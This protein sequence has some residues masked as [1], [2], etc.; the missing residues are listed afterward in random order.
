MLLISQWPDVKNGEY[1]LIEKIKQTGYKIVVTDYFGFNV[2]TGECLNQASLANDF[3]FA[4]SFH[5]D[6]PK[7]L[8]IPTFLWV[9]NP[10]EFM[11]LRG[12]YRTV[13]LHHLRAYDDYLYNGSD[14]LKAHIRN[15]VGSEWRES[16]LEMF[17]S[18]SSEAMLPPKSPDSMGTDKARK[19]F[20]CGVNWER[21]TDRAGR[22]QGLLDILQEQDAGDFYGPNKLE[23]ISPW[24][25]F[26]SYR[27]EIPF[28]GVSM[29]RIMQDYGAV[30]AISSPAH[31]KSRTSSSRVFEGIAAG[32]PV[33]SDKNPHVQAL[34]GDLVYYFHGA[35]EAERAESIL[36]ALQQINQNPEE[37][38]EKVVKAQALMKQRYCFEP[39]FSSALAA[40]KRDAKRR[41]DGTRKRLDV[42]LFLHDSEQDQPF[43]N[44]RHVVEAAAYAAQR[45]NAEVF[46]NCCSEEGAAAPAQPLPPDVHW[47]P[48]QTSDITAQK[49]AGLRMGEKVALLTSHASGEFAVFMT[50]F[51]FPHYDSLSKA[52]DWFMNDGANNS[53]GV[54]VGGFY[55]GDLA[56]K[57]PLGT[58]GIL[59]NNASTALYRWTQNSLAEHQT[60]TLMFHRNAYGLLTEEKIGRFDVLLPISVILAANSHQLPVYRSRHVLLRVQQGHFHRHYEA[61]RKATEK[62]FWAQHYELVTNYTHELNAL[63]DVHHEDP[64]ACEI[65]DKVSGH[66]LPSAPPLDPAVHAVNQ[67]IGRLRPVYRKFK[68]ARDILMFKRTS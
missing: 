43:T 10:L 29:A 5:Y 51:D 12:D 60:G 31:M 17:P 24:E 66:G 68:K 62:G 8:N 65:I 41:A 64:L 2:D 49:W 27:G 67:V 14:T 4:I 32:V 21:G 46:I 28:D 34:F 59:R 54:H 48:W 55:V 44:M 39:C 37:A 1:E 53:G 33:I 11:H 36:H 9:A 63:Y 57:A 40:V 23:G 56:H 7:F 42:F 22:A 13:L 25:G 47:K 15:I 20:Y 26:K 6:T 35:T 18:C 52:L 16:S 50:Q 3:D 58:V 61:Y 45:N 38:R 30:L 19:V